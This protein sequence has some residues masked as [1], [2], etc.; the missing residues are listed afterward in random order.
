MPDGLED[1]APV[2]RVIDVENAVVAACDEVASV[3]GPRGFNR[4]TYRTMTS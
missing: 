1:A 4:L 3:G 2:L